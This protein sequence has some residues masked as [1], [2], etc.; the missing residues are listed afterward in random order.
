MSM[1][2]E[3]NRAGG[4][5]LV[6]AAVVV[7][8]VA[9]VAALAY[10]SIARFRPRANLANTA[11]EL[12][13]LIHGARQAALANGRDV[14]VLLFPDQATSTGTGRV[15]V[16]EDAASDFFSDAAAVNFDGY[17]PGTL[18]T[19]PGDEVLSTLD[20]DAGVTLGPATGR[21]PGATL[22]R[23]YDLIVVS[24]DCSFCSAGAGR[25]GAI[26]FDARGRAAFFDGNGL[27]LSENN[28]DRGASFT[29]ESAETGDLRTLVITS[30]TGSIR[31]LQR[32]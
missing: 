8:I 11:T 5:T 10:T 26:R 3:R 28:E 1:S 18:A 6:E 22:E 14:L 20:F 4:F 19:G 21:G 7:A 2:H 17:A 24:T 9:V 32:G 12:Q 29:I 25:R 16:Y 13:S 30:A 23:P 15:I 27:P 31:V